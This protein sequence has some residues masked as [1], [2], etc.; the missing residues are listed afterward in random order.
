MSH[1][2]IGL[3]FTNQS[4]CEKWNNNA[5]GGIGARGRRIRNAIISRTGYCNCSCHCNDNNNNDND[6]CDII[7]DCNENFITLEQA[8]SQGGG[9]ND[10][11][12]FLCSNRNLILTND[13]VIESGAYVIFGD[14]ENPQGNLP[15][16]FGSIDRAKFA[17][18]F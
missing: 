4:K 15:D 8:K 14:I 1:R 17:G 3:G 9:R 13:F 10:E 11:I 5:I 6:N 16:G 18:V 2:I 7:A 12:L